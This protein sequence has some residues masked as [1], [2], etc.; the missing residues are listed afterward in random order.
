MYTQHMHPDIKNLHLEC[1]WDKYQ[2]NLKARFG[3][4][5]SY[6]LFTFNALRLLGGLADQ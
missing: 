3:G 5:G 1:R 4:G 6:R 2:N